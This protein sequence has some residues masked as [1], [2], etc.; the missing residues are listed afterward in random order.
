MVLLL[1]RLTAANTLNNHVVSGNFDYPV[2]KCQ[3]VHAGSSPFLDAVGCHASSNCPSAHQARNRRHNYIMRVLA[4]AAKEAGLNSKFEPDTFN[5]LLGD[6]SQ[7]NCK[8]MFPRNASQLY[9]DR[10]NAVVNAVDLQF[11][12]FNFVCARVRLK[13]LLATVVCTAPCSSRVRF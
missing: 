1:F 3:S 12:C 4:A 8:R 10:V 6:F 11:L 13:P 2:Q 7:A 9:K 5:L